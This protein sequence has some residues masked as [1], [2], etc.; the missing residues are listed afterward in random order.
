MNISPA[1]L[2]EIRN[3]HKKSAVISI[4]QATKGGLLRGSNEFIHDSDIHV[5]VE[6]GIATTPKNRFKIA[7]NSYYS[8]FLEEHPQDA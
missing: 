7:D 6:N 5:M 4:C 3:I 2:R 1:E 8:V